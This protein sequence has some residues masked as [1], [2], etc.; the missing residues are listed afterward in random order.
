LQ[1]LFIDKI[2]KKHVD[3]II[4][5]MS[6]SMDSDS[7]GSTLI[8]MELNGGK[9]KENAGG[10]FPFRKS[11]FFVASNS[12]WD[13]LQETQWQ[14]QWLVDVLSGFTRA[15]IDGVYLGFPIT[16]P[17]VQKLITQTKSLIHPNQMYYGSVENFN[18]LRVIRET[19]D[20]ANVLSTM[21]TIIN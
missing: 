3:T 6:N 20:P 1:A 13:L 15:G 9:I 2:T 12:S 7:T 17:N 5:T 14:E 16:F 18:K 19:I 21:G 8:E 4:E 11:D 10:S